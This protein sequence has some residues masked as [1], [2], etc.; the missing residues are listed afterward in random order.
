M[1]EGSVKRGWSRAVALGEENVKT[2]WT[3]I[4]STTA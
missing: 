4:S 3:L 2:H 1:L